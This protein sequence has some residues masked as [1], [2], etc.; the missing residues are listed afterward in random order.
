MR[1]GLVALL[2]VAYAPIAS[3]QTLPARP[4]GSGP[5]PLSS[6]DVSDAEV[7][8]A[9]EIIV[10]LQR[11]E[12][13]M[14]RKYGEPD[15]MTEQQLR[16]VQ[17]ETMRE[18]QLLLQKKTLEEDLDAGRLELIMISAKKDSTLHRR[19]RTAVERTKRE[20]KQRPETTTEEAAADRR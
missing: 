12:A 11:Q 17:Q 6:S 18:R 15:D 20:K 8:S 4:T 2:L 1:I 10:S 9:A 5:A 13:E 7:E 3:A 14:E 16:R 19:V